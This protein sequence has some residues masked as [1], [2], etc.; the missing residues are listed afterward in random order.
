MDHDYQKR[1]TKKCCVPGCTDNISTRHRFPKD[2][3]L[4]QEWKNN[5][6]NP[7][8]KDLSVTKVYN[9]Y[10]ICNRHFSKN[11]LVVG[12]KRG[13]TRTAVPTLHLG[14]FNIIN[15]NL[16]YSSFCFYLNKELIWLISF[17]VKVLMK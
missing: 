11:C 14:R 2:P 15:W 9:L 13:L 16:C 8:L 17:Q 7:A 12:T 10:Y 1:K 4:F 3:E 6:N 5:V